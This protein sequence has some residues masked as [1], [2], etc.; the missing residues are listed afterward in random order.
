MRPPTAGAAAS[1]VA[2]ER[3][4]SSG[5]VLH[6]IRRSFRLARAGRSVYNPGPMSRPWQYTRSRYFLMQAVMWLV[7]G[8]TV[9]L[10]ALISRHHRGSTDDLTEK[11]DV[12]STAGGKVSILLPKGWIIETR[13]PKPGQGSALKIIARE[14]A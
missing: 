10:A 7:L 1:A 6:P 12:T 8:T 11:V 2:R 4:D 14:S 13:R 9:G 3:G 5:N